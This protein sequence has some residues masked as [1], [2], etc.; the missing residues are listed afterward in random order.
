[1]LPLLSA[2]DLT[3][4][5]GTRS[6]LTKINLD[7]F[8]VRVSVL[9]DPNGAGKTTLF[10]ILTGL[11]SIN[12]VLWLLVFTAGFRAAL[13]IAIIEPYETYIT[14]EVYIAPGLCCMVLLF[15][16]MQGSLAIVKW[17]A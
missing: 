17:A 15:N 4:F 10:G 13:G 16:G 6:A 11:L 5:Y 7:L 2:R 9:L 12:E 1:M 3:H 14:Y 8:S